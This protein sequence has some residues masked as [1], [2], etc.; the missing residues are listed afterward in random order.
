M[1]HTITNVT[2]IFNVSDR[3]NDDSFQICAMVD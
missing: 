3:I 1:I 2:S